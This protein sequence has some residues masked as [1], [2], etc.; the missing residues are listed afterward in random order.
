MGINL[1]L[2]LAEQAFYRA[3]ELAQSDARL[4]SEWFERTQRVS[5]ARA[6][7]YVPML[8]TALL[9]KATDDRVSALSLKESA[10][11]NAYSARGPGHAVLVPL[12]VT[13]GISLRT[14]G[15]EPLNNQPFFR[16]D[17][18][19]KSMKI[20]STN[21]VDF[22]YL[23]ETLEEADFLR[24]GDALNALA[25]FLRVR[26][27]DP[28]SSGVP[29][30]ANVSDAG[31]SVARLAALHAAEDSEG[32][33]R[34]QALVAAA[35]DLLSEHVLTRRV[36]DP[37]AAIPGDVIVGVAESGIV[38]EVKQRYIA[39]HEIRQL[40]ERA[41]EAG[42]SKV[43]VDALVANHPVLAEDDLRRFAAS[44]GVLLEIGHD[45]AA[46][47]RRCMAN[48]TLSAMDAASTFATQYARRMA[49]IECHVDGIQQWVS[50]VSASQEPA[51]A[52]DPKALAD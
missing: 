37:S 19:S 28:A 9:A 30:I 36:N 44:R 41:S 17:R 25:A 50:S 45:A 12:C 27:L 16:Y 10:G 13:E 4:P 34:G 51:A 5:Q 52:H 39:D 22:D 46:L 7:T 42:W 18:I 21:Q 32:G 6:K 14:T 2:K 24:N 38:R 15:R 48:S 35:L 29:R 33:R 26:L 40:V 31:E 1:D 8:G 49:E 11:H 20:R 3:L 23:V 43:A 47:I